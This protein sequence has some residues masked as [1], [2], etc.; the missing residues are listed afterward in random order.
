MSLGDSYKF[1]DESITDLFEQR[2]GQDISKALDDAYAALDT[3]VR[4]QNR[5]C[6]NNLFY[7]GE[8]DFR[9]SPRCQ[10]QNWLLVAISAILMSSMALKCKSI[11]LV[12]DAHDQPFC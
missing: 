5:N 9:K 12:R 11:H 8:T 10:V 2:I 3:T 7:M 6:I 1:L 4:D